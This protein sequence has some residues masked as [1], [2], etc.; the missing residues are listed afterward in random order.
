MHACGEP[1]KLIRGLVQMDITW[2]QQNVDAA[3]N[4]PNASLENALQVVDD[5]RSR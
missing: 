2:A 1:E 3:G 4:S 5:T